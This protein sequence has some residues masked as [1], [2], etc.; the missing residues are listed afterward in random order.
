MTHFVQAIRLSRAARRRTVLL[1]LGTAVLLLSG[2]LVAPADGLVSGPK[3]DG[4]SVTPQG[5][6]VTP[7]GTQTDV[8]PG[9]MSIAMSPLGDTLLVTTGGY[10]DNSLLVVDPRDG[11]VRQGFRA[12]GGN[13]HGWWQWEEGHGA[14][15]YIG[16]AFSPDGSRAYAA[17]GTGNSLHAF[18]ITN[19]VVSEDQ[20]ILVASNRGS[21]IYP[22]GIAMSADG[23]R[24]YVAGNLTDS[25]FVVDP[26]ARK[27]LAE[28]AVG[29]LPYGVALNR[30]GT[31]AFVT[32]WGARTVTVVDLAARAV[33]R[34]LTTGT[35]PSAI[36]ASPV[37]DEIYVANTDSDTVS[38][39]DGASAT[40]LR[41]IDLRP[42][43]GAPVGASPNALALS[44]DG[45]TLYVAN[46]G[47][48]DI[49]VVTLARA[50][51]TKGD[52][53]AGL[54]PTAWY[55]SGVALDVSGKTLFVINM[56]GLGVGPTPVDVYWPTLMHGTLSRVRV[57]PPRQLSAYTAQVFANNR[58][59]APPSPAKGSVIPARIG[60]PSPITHVIYVLKENRSYDQVLGDLE[61]G[62][63]DPSLAIFGASVTPNHHELS[64]RF[65]T[66]DNFYTDAEVSADGW[67][68]ANGANANT[69]IQKNWPLDYA[70]F[71]R[72]YDFGGFLGLGYVSESAGLPGDE[73][74]T[75]F[76]WDTVARAGVSYYNFG[77]FMSNPPV[78]DEAIPGLEGHTDLLYPGWDLYVTDQ[79]RMD[80]WLQV[81]QGYQ[82]AGSMPRMQFVYLPSDHTFGTTP[83]ARRPVSMVADND[84][85][86]GRLVEA[87]SH[88]AFWPSTVIF[89][90]EDDA[91]DGPDH[92]DAHRSI[93]LAISPYTQTATVDSTFYSTVSALRTMELL[94][95]AQPMSQYDA[96]ATPM[97][98][99]FSSTPSLRPYRALVP[100]VSIFARNG[101]DAPMAAESLLIDFSKPDRIPMALMNAIL[102]KSVRGVDSPVPATRHTMTAL[103][104]RDDGADDD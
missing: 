82:Q 16:L 99:A 31:R 89:V 68:W 64:R 58:F 55:P 34:T 86:L 21:D 12:Q 79:T 78:I 13:S 87:V 61:V 49:A 36:L 92:V 91:Q 29:H 71:D 73:P 56:K 59:D 37:N 85:A 43:A 23:S 98:A 25:L 15:Y 80:R 101:K 69:Y 81:F 65:V 14:S 28:I 48:N 2:A 62:N 50:G 39:L 74:G 67:S 57:P 6:R 66:F 42:Y 11:T 60:D 94:L 19:G 4:T 53:V 76:L 88:S 104:P 40:L 7:S 63:G 54:I 46:A 17:D 32:S 33:V 20:R 27:Q 5:W 102:W 51:G 75:T 83:K 41:A 26:V 18:T 84:L 77:F 9:P 52:T 30:A 97:S 8:G 103:H 3:P 38:V 10:E 24:L 95:G 93:C 45:K 96:L 44:S 72:P 70:G 35:H 90:M 47:D 100:A 22:A 1:G